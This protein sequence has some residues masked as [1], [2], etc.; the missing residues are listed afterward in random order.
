MNVRFVS[1]SLA[2][3]ATFAVLCLTPADTRAQV[4][5]ENVNMVSGTQW[6]GGDPFL[7]R[8]NEPTIA[9]SSVN[10][11]H[12]MAGANDYRSVDVPD[13]AFGKMAAGDAWLGVFKSLDGGQTWKSVLL[14]G[15]PQDDSPQGKASPLQSVM[16]VPVTFPDD[17]KKW[18]TSVKLPGSAD[19]VM[20]AGTDGMFYYL[21]INFARDKSVSRLFLGRFIDQNNKENGDATQGKDPIQYLDTQIVARSTDTALSGGKHIFIDKPWMTVDVPGNT[22]A[23]CTV[24]DPDKPATLTTPQGTRKI[25]AG[26]VYVGWAQFAPGDVSSDIMITWSGD[27][28]LTWAPPQKLN[29][30]NSLVNQGIAI[31][32]EPITGRVYVAWRRIA[33]GKQ[34]D[35]IM[36][37]R[38]E[39]RKRHFA[40]P[41]VVARLVPFDLGTG[42]GQARTQT[43]PSLAI[44][45]DGAKSFAHIAW[46]ARSGVNGPSRIWMTNA[47]VYPKPT[48]DDD[49]DDPDDY[50]DETRVKWTAAAQVKVGDVKDDYGHTLTRGHQYMPALTASQ[51]RLVLFYYDSRL[52]HTRRYYRPNPFV[53]DPA[54]ATKKIWAPSSDGRFYTEELGP[55]GDL[56]DAGLAALNKVFGNVGLNPAADFDDSALTSTRHT[57]DVRV[58]MALPSLAPD[59][60]SVLVSRFPL[61][62]TGFETNVDPASTATPPVTIDFTMPAFLA[63]IDP[64]VSGTGSILVV[65]KDKNEAKVLEQLKLNVPGYP[66]F[67]GSTAAFMGDYIDIQGQNFAIAK[68][69]TATGTINRWVYNTAASLA[70][71]FHAV[72]TSNQDVKAPWDP[73]AMKYDWSKY[74]PVTLRLGSGTGGGMLYDGG[75]TSPNISNPN[76]SNTAPIA[77]CD[78][79][80]TGSR[81]QNIY[82][83]RITEGLQVSTP[84]NAKFLNGQTPVGFVIGAANSTGTAMTVTFGAPT[85]DPAG[86]TAPDASYTTDFTSPVATVTAV[87]APYSSV[88]RTLFV[89]QGGTIN[90]AP[91]LL[92][93]VTESVGCG[94]TLQP[95]C[96]SGSLTF[97]PPIAISQLAPPDG[98]TGD[99]SREAYTATIGAPNISNPNISNPNISN[100]NISNPNISNPNISNPNISNPNISSP[101]ISNPNISNPNISN[102]NI[103]NPNISNPNISNPNISNPNISNPNI[104]NSAISDASYTFTN[105]GNTSASYFVKVVGDATKVPSPLQLIV[106]KT[107]KTPAA[108][109]C[110]LKE[111]AH[112]QLVVSVPD[113]SKDIV[114]PDSKV[115]TGVSTPN[116]SNATL[117]LAPGETATVT[118]RGFVPVTEMAK[119]VAAVT[120]APV[121][122]TAPPTATAATTTYR[123][124]GG[125]VGNPVFVKIPTVTTIT[126]SGV[127]TLAHVNV[128]PGSTGSGT[129]TGTLTFVRT[130]AGIDTILGSV[131][132]EYFGGDTPFFPTSPATGDTITV[133]YAGD[134]TYAASTSSLVPVVAMGQLSL[135]VRAYASGATVYFQQAGA[136]L[137]ADTMTFNGTDMGAP[138]STGNYYLSFASA[139]TPGSSVRVEAK[140]AGQVVASATGTWPQQPVLGNSLGG[141]SI[142]ADFDLNVT[143]NSVISA[144]Y[145]QVQAYCT[146]LPCG[147]NGNLVYPPTTTFLYPA[148]TFTVGQQLEFWLYATN[149]LTVS[150]ATPMGD[151]FAA[152]TANRT[153]SAVSGLVTPPPPPPPP[154][155]NSG[156]PMGFPRFAHAA[157]YDSNTNSIK[158]VGGMKY[159]APDANGSI[160]YDQTATVGLEEAYMVATGQWTVVQTKVY[161]PTSGTYVPTGTT[162][163]VPFY[164]A[165]VVTGTDLYLMG[166]QTGGSMIGVRSYL[167]VNSW[168]DNWSVPD[169]S[170]AWP[171]MGTPR[172]MAAAAAPGSICLPSSTT[173]F[174]S[175]V[176]GGYNGAVLNTSEFRTNLGS[177]SAGPSMNV[178][179]YGHVAVMVGNRYYAIGG[180]GVVGGD[181]LSDMEYC[182]VGVNAAG[183]GF[184]ITPWTRVA[185]PASVPGRYGAT[186]AVVNGKIYV[187]GGGAN[188]QV[189]G[190]VFIF[191]TATNSWSQGAN[192]GV[193]VSQAAAAVVNGKI[194]L[195]GGDKG[196]P[197]GAYGYVQVITP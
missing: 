70:P 31:A 29:T 187:M 5:G 175:L 89:R 49:A 9:V 114:S 130:R 64:A 161:D 134:A 141:T 79:A 143:W 166:G 12:L 19:P 139:P 45:S 136:W 71:V 138:T 133:V 32:I 183:T 30:V 34:T 163:A 65:S 85:V 110:V 20:R 76:I 116:I 115:F 153:V 60:S 150:G 86:V 137:N 63:G 18:G 156:F 27:C 195:V 185:L 126:Q 165:S 122:A 146:G 67:K 93:T 39:G 140:I 152:L 182:D 125:I 158:V 37:T 129:I 170:A 118:L 104:S 62:L 119:A 154:G 124:W 180:H 47:Q 108:V 54:D 56:A 73:V 149:V 106:S 52:D 57:V 178:A 193:A 111:I 41:R 55:V 113:I 77:V 189:R 4:V 197:A 168:F 151:P 84:Q 172:T 174:H 46:A 120:P 21:G 145:Y 33:S 190:E 109:E 121:P 16:V 123:N 155:G 97:N 1:R 164:P 177:W 3:A 96:R 38:S 72:W 48:G 36:A 107:Y 100:P 74:T 14:P 169:G 98:F 81:D 103:S 8:Q 26:T 144:G 135:G 6:P 186:A 51:G 194:Y 17:T 188:T 147:G 176:S 127:N 22:T 95:A 192:L 24:P 101:N 59:F 69:T 61:G 179:R 88:F 167:S 173:C 117:S 50:E 105:N 160:F 132:V 157:V 35:A 25:L 171:W 82:T 43:M 99:A 94:G 131:T 44:S 191:D 2:L 11:Q 184:Q 68:T 142:W 78:P 53:T 83:A 10:P 66:M 112:D 75:R 42:L 80:S 128:A 87:I 162:P 23:T 13:P 91:T 148:N 90:S 58:G 15:Y 102:P 92:V 159:T 196:N 40:A 181:A 28:G 7:Q